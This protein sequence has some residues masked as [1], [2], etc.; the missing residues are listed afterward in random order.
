MRRFV[1]TLLAGLLLAVLAPTAGS[2]AD[3]LY[4]VT[5]DGR[6]LDAKNRSAI[7]HRGVVYVNVV[8]AVKAFDGLLTFGRG[9]S[10][11][12]TVN[13][14]TLHYRI[15]QRTA[16]LENGQVIK[17]P[18]APFDLNGDTYVPIA[19]IATLATARYVVDTSHHV[20]RLTLGATSGFDAPPTMPPEQGED[21]ADLSPLQAL[22]IKPSAT[23]DAQGLHA[24]A[25]ITNTTNKAYVL[26]FAGSQQF[27][28]VV[29]RNGSEVWTSQSNTVTGAPSTFHLEP[30][31]TT[32]VTADWPGF[33]KA[34]PGRYS[35]RV[36]LVRAIPIDTPPVSLD[37][38]TPS[39]SP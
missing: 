21:V 6:G 14:R 36:R 4:G 27:V 31:E 20:V 22:T 30:G 23:A 35:L 9:G 5:V 32:T 19:S 17:L 10:L 26:A 1:A 2:S 3:I 12:V 25:E 39:S 15:G 11:R 33:S 24:R 8:R 13:G 7:N 18:G 16:Q 38:V 29:V 37:S 34:G 28:F